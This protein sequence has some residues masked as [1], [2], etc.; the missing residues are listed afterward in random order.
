MDSMEYSSEQEAGIDQAIMFVSVLV[1]LM[2]HLPFL[3]IY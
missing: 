2:Y 1:P 3:I